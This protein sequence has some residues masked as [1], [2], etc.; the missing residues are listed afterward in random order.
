MEGSPRQ[1]P[2]LPALVKLAL[3]SSLSHAFG[4]LL[5]IHLRASLI[6]MQISLLRILEEQP[7]NGSSCALVATLQW[8][9]EAISAG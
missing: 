8:R 3:H 6:A 1:A 5:K 4:I 7:V 9:Q 2:I